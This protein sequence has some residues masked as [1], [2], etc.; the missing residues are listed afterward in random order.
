MAYLASFHAGYAV[1]SDPALASA[2]PDLAAIERAVSLDHVNPVYA[3][4]RA[5]TLRFYGAAPD[6][7]GAAFQEAFRRYPLYPV[8]H[9]EYGGYLA[10]LGRL[11][12]A[13]TQIDIARLVSDIDRERL[14]AIN[15]AE[16]VL[17]ADGI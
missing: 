1:A 15:A 5:R 11:E 2:R 13:R 9:A 8:A 6:V 16:A 3:L 12:E 14:D 17:A 7:V 10:S 4:E